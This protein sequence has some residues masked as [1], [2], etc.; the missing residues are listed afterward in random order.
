MTCC[1]VFVSKATGITT[2][3]NIVS[4]PVNSNNK[5][6]HNTVHRINTVNSTL[7]DARDATPTSSL[8]CLL[9]WQA[10]REV[11]SPVCHHRLDNITAAVLQ[12]A[13]HASLV[14]LFSV[15]TLLSSL[16]RYSTV[17]TY[18]QKSGNDRKGLSLVTHT[19]MECFFACCA[20]MYYTADT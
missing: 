18:V 14:S 2:W 5:N 17:C 16:C 9:P 7:R 12:Y 11:L 20:C 10:A 6:S 3:N 4:T 1:D 13:C 8:S 19:T 15:V